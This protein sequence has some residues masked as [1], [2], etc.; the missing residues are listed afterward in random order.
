MTGKLEYPD[1]SAQ[2]IPDGPT[3]QNIGWH[4]MYHYEDGPD[5]IWC[6]VCG[7]WHQE[8]RRIEDPPIF[9][10]MFSSVTG[11]T[12]EEVT[13]TRTLGYGQE[14]EYREALDSGPITPNGGD[15]LVPLPKERLDDHT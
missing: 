10:V 2:L 4:E 13:I 14:L 15:I 5:E 11:N 6:E 12:F 3:S 8:Q 7:D 1:W 9:G